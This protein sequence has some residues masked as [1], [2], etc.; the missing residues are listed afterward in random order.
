MIQP[1][2]LPHHRVATLSV[3]AML[4]GAAAAGAQAQG[5]FAAVGF[6]RRLLSAS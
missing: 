2:S 3:T 6:F 4:L 1:F 5:A